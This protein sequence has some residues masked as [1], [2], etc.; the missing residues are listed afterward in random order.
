MD[1]TFAWDYNNK[2]NNNNNDKN[3]HPNFLKETVQ[4]VGIRNK[5]QGSRDKTYVEFGTEDQVFSDN[6]NNKGEFLGKLTH[7]IYIYIIGMS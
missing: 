6:Q 3:T 4:G 5:G 7:I 2:N 1:F